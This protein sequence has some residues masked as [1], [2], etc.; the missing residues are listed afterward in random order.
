MTVTA[1]AAAGMSITMTA[2]AATATVST[3]DIMKD[4]FSAGDLPALFISDHFL[5][6][7]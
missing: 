7:V 4:K 2:V 1:N 5:L 3:A 6:I